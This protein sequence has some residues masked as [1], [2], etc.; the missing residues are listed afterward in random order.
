[1]TDSGSRSA[2]AAEA[3]DATEAA[4]TGVTFAAVG[5][6]VEFFGAVGGSRRSGE[7]MVKLD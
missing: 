4:D 5:D 7:F 3:A 1:M 6:E 2:A